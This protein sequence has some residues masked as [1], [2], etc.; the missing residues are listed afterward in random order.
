MV[1]DIREDVH[2]ALAAGTQQKIHGGT[3]EP[4]MM[5]DPKAESVMKRGQLLQ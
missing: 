2:A 5:M 4:A 3:I 1:N